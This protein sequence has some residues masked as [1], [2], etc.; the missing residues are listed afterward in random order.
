M[1]ARSTAMQVYD[2][3]LPYY[4]YTPR[5]LAFSPDGR[6]LAVG[7]GPQATVIDTLAGAANTVPVAKE[8]WAVTGLGFVADGGL[9]A[10]PAGRLAVYDVTS[11]DLRCQLG[12]VE[13]G[14]HTVVTTPDG[15]VL[16]AAVQD[17]QGF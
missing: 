17:Q 9:L 7:G 3:R 13:T 1:A 11:G 4:T 16:L 5:A 12:V 10:S 8:Q 15:K 14:G 6:H 2:T